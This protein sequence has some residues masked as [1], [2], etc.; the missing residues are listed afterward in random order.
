MSCVSKTS[1]CLNSS[2]V[3]KRVFIWKLISGFL[4]T[5]PC[6]WSDQQC[7]QLIYNAPAPTPTQRRVCDLWSCD[8]LT[9]KFSIS[10]VHVLFQF[11]DKSYEQSQCHKPPLLPNVT[12]H[13]ASLVTLQERLH[14]WSL[15]LW[16]LCSVSQR[17]IVLLKVAGINL[18]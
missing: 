16:S 11:E 3:R 1:L 2:G 10:W 4:R 13:S 12:T 9:F 15:V 5:Q 7:R 17:S 6:R 8:I 14:V 18:G